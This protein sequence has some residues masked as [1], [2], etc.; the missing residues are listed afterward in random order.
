MKCWYTNAGLL[1][2][3]FNK[4]KFKFVSDKPDIV[5]VTGVNCKFSG[6]DVEFIM[7]ATKLYKVPLL[8]Y[9]NVVYHM[10]G[11]LGRGKI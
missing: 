9:I 11:K 1:F 5:A 6:S 4:L 10:A 2:N 3:K 8:I 7:M